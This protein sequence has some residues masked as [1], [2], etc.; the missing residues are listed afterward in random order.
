MEDKKQYVKSL[1]EFKKAV[2]EFGN[3][4]NDF[5]EIFSKLLPDVESSNEEDTWET[6]C[7]LKDGDEYYLLKSFGDFQKMEWTNHLFDELALMQG[8]IFKTEEAVTLE[9]KRRNL[10]TRFNAFRDECNGDWEADWTNAWDCKFFVS[11]IESELEVK[12]VYIANDFVLFGYF[13][14]PKDAERAIE[15]FGDEI[16]E[17]FVEKRLANENN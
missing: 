10:L 1:V 5:V 9:V 12:P 13:K 16:K 17:L 2:V 6:K 15:L 7:P 14:N 3:K 4:V 8:N 11:I